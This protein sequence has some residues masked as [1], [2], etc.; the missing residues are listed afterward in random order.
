MAQTYKELYKKRL[1]H[2]TTSF[3]DYDLKALTKDAIPMAIIVKVMAVLMAFTSLP[4]ALTQRSPLHIEISFLLPMIWIS[5]TENMLQHHA[6]KFGRC[7]NSK[8]L[9]LSNPF[10]RLGTRGFYINE[11]TCFCIS[12]GPESSFRILDLRTLFYST[13]STI[14]ARFAIF[15]HSSVCL[16]IKK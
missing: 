13:M 5:K 12:F 14:I 10:V 15:G 11:L 8:L 4:D 3:K 7:N 6:L 16:I 9:F 2:L 1:S